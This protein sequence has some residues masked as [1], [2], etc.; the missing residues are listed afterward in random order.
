MFFAYNTLANFVREHDG[1]DEKQCPRYIIL[2]IFY[3]IIHNKSKK[4]TKHLTYA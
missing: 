4:D 2:G 1:M 3:E